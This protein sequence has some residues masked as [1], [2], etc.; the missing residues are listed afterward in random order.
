MH[1]LRLKGEIDDP[2][3]HNTT[4]TNR[5]I[6]VRSNQRSY[7][8]IVF[9]LRNWIL[10]YTSFY[11]STYEYNNSTLI[12]SATY[13]YY[14][15]LHIRLGRTSFHYFFV[16][17]VLVLLYYNIILSADGSQLTI[18]SLVTNLAYIQHAVSILQCNNVASWHPAWLWSL[19][20]MLLS[21]S[22]HG[23]RP[24]F[25]QHSTL[26]T[27]TEQMFWHFPPFNWGMLRRSRCILIFLKHWSS[28][29]N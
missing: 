17:A 9:S 12:S 20:E 21:F 10:I 23:S 14:I 2:D 11:E 28:G 18:N 29:I 25:F 26:L 7:L 24:R 19:L 8:S 13:Q 22:P 27:V 15:L 4:C 6:T 16:R 1:K 5:P 3:L